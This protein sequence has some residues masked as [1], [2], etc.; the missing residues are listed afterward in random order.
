M[1]TGEE[2]CNIQ[3]GLLDTYLKYG[4]YRFDICIID[5]PVACNNNIDIIKLVDFLKTISNKIIF[6]CNNK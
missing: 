4:A 2:K 5:E 6:I 3:T 1:F